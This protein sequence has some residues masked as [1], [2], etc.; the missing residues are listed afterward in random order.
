MGARCPTLA[1]T[2]DLAQGF[3]RMLRERHGNRLA[4][5][6]EHAE[7]GDVPELRAFTLGLRRT[8]TRSWPG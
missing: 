3:A 1:T 6:V 7:A 2:V 5:W 4:A 8:G